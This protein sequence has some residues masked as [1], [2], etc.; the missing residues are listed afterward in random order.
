MNP[1]YWLFKPLFRLMIYP[2][3]RLLRWMF[4]RQIV[5]LPSRKETG[6]AEDRE[7]EPGL[8]VKEIV[9]AQVR[10]RFQGKIEVCLWRHYLKDK[11]AV[12]CFPK[13]SCHGYLQK[14][15]WPIEKK[16][17]PAHWIQ[18]DYRQCGKS[19][20]DSCRFEDLVDDAQGVLVYAKAFLGLKEESFVFLAQGMGVEI[21][22]ALNRRYMGKIKVYPQKE[23]L[24]FTWKN[25]SIKGV[26]AWFMGWP[27]GFC[28]IFQKQNLEK[29][30]D[31]S[32]AYQKIEGL[33]GVLEPNQKEKE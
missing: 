11:T 32:V 24:A 16:E 13:T 29:D 9:R 7:E 21:A 20:G 10:T 26:L 15:L 3:W 25:M 14:C 6:S 17:L 33:K 28:E 30:I 4:Y 5:V 18:Y 22:H 2:L 8:G 19:K 27:W 23:R 1:L 12:I 31:Y